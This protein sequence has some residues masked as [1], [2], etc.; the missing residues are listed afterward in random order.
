MARIGEL[1]KPVLF[2]GV[3]VLAVLMTA[4]LYFTLYKPLSERNQVERKRLA[5]R[6][7][8]VESMKKYENDLPKLNQQIALLREQLEIQKRILPDEKEAD[9]F[10]HL[11]QNTAQSSGIAIRRW[12][13][14]PVAAREYYTEVP[15]E[16]ELDGPYYALL[17]FFQR[18]GQLERIINVSGLQ[19]GALKGEDAK[20]RRGYHYAPEESVGGVCTAITFFSRDPALAGN[21]AAPKAAAK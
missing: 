10:I 4:A 11:L 19:L 12:T 18:V 20:N 8:E 17:N 2:G 6:R 9:N 5:A 1:P 3:A 16:L 15:F 14:K 13:A 21:S 7:A